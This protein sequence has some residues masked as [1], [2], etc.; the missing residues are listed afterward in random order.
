MC[1]TPCACGPFTVRC[2]ISF[3]LDAVGHLATPLYK[4]LDMGRGQ[5]DDLR[6]ARRAVYRDGTIAHGQRASLGR[7]VNSLWSF[8]PQSR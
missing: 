1:G 8:A 3:Q 6:A 2:V 7:E 4:L 5:R